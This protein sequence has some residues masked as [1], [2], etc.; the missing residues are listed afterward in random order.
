MQ[1]VALSDET[2][3][4]LRQ[5]A[6]LRGLDTDT[7]A[8]ESL[9]ISLAVLRQGNTVPHKPHHTMKFSAIA[10]TGRSAVDIDAEIEASRAEWE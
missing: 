7:C 8:E 6:A 4:Y 2:A 3:N 9:A 5:M 1:T 10:P